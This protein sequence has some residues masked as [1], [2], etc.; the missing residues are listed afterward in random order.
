MKTRM[1]G[2]VGLGNLIPSSVYVIATAPA[3]RTRPTLPQRR[4]PGALPHDAGRLPRNHH[5]ESAKHSRRCA[6]RKRR[7][8]EHAAHDFGE[9][10]S[11]EDHRGGS[12]GDRYQE[13]CGNLWLEN[14]IGTKRQNGR[15]AFS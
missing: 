2:L 10:H 4:R 12:T 7:N 14:T 3:G 1:V 6:G 8:Q 11:G 5:P 9:A 13:L 15:T